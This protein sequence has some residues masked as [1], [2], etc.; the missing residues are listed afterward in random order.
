[1]R[2]KGK[3]RVL[4]FAGCAVAVFVLNLLAARRRAK[5]R[6]WPVGFAHRG[7]SSR[8]PENTLE[9]FSLAVRAGAGGLEIDAHLTLDGEV[10]VIHDA[11]V[12]R[13][14]D[15]MGFVREMNLDELR[16]LDAGYRFSPDGESHPYKG[17]GLRVPTLREIYR[18]FPTAVVNVE[19]KGNSPGIEECLLRTIEEAGALDGTLVASE[20]HSTMRRFRRISRGRVATSASRA[21]ILAFFLLSKLRLQRLLPIG[22]EALQVPVRSERFEV[23]TPRFIEAAHSRGIRVD[24]WTINEAEEMRRLLDLGVDVIMTDRPEEL[25]K[26]LRARIHE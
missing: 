8:A 5:R 12:D 24:A 7:D 14:T 21:E 11:R 17:K 2:E 26:V 19:I 16:R 18:S 23:V 22:Y 15:G 9:A 4:L 6:G 1:M 10:V 20:V 3:R 25:A 13:T